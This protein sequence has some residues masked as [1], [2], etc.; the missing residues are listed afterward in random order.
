[1]WWVNITFLSELCDLCH[2]RGNTCQIAL[3]IWSPASCCSLLHPFSRSGKKNMKH[4]I[5]QLLNCIGPPLWLSIQARSNN[6]NI[7][8]IQKTWHHWHILVIPPHCLIYYNKSQLTKMCENMAYYPGS[9][10]KFLAENMEW[11]KMLES[12]HI[13]RIIT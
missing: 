5:G 7:S 12:K 9:H 13:S 1:M 10:K 3:C 8:A 4:K 11:C 2:V 6:Y